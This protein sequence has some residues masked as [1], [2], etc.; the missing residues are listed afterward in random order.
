MKMNKYG[1]TVI[2]CALLIGCTT[3]YNSVIAVTDV[4]DSAMKQWAQAN[5][6]RQTTPE[7]NATVIRL[8][9]NYREAAGA[10]A[11]SLRLY[12]ETKNAANLVAALET[13]KQGATPLVDFIVQVLAPSKGTE[14]KTQLASAT[15]P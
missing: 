14:L 10:A 5:K 15:K 12:K 4:V 3:F 1:I 13:A 11:Q 7:F 9:D 8:H 6:A 2:V